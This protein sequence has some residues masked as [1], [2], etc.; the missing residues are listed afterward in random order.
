MFYFNIIVA[1]NCIARVFSTSGNPLAGVHVYLRGIGVNYASG[2]TDEFGR[3]RFRDI[4]VAE[5]APL[6]LS[7]DLPAGARMSEPS[8]DEN[9]WI[10]PHTVSP[11]LVGYPGCTYDGGCSL[12]GVTFY[13]EL[14]L[15]ELYQAI[16]GAVPTA[17]VGQAD[18]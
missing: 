13:A 6:E 9:G 17:F 12:A 5:G 11:T 16:V 14:P 1:S 2:V 3:F 7:I 18:G 10:Q 4:V 8:V 15:G